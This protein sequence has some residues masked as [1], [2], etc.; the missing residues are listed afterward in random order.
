[1]TRGKNAGNPCGK[2]EAKKI[3]RGNLDDFAFLN[4][5]ITC[6]KHL[7]ILKRRI[8]SIETSIVISE[9][10]ELSQELSQEKA[11]KLSQEK[12][13]ELS[14]E[15]AQELSLNP[16]RSIETSL[17]KSEYV[18]LAHKFKPKPKPK[19][20]QS[21][22]FSPKNKLDSLNQ[23]YPAVKKNK[24]DEKDKLLKALSKINVGSQLG[25]RGAFKEITSKESIEIEDDLL[26][27]LLFKLGL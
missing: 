11:Q 12:A 16:T 4:G 18:V 15:K 27:S 19:S 13:Q 8:K 20:E 10:Q 7:V 24:D 14:Q 5:K 23:V 26:A 17:V 25:A 6:S 21:S 9:P 2:S 3:K 22:D 1:M